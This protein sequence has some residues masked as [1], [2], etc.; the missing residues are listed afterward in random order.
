MSDSP[1]PHDPTDSQTIPGDAPGSFEQAKEAVEQG[2]AEGMGFVVNRHDPFLVV[3]FGNVVLNEPLPKSIKTL[4]ESLGATFTEATDNDNL[5]CIYKGQLPEELHGG[6]PVLVTL[7]G[8][9]G[10]IPVR[11]FDSGWTPMTGKH[12]EDTPGDVEQIDSDALEK[13]LKS[14]DKI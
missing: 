5:R 3:E 11:L 12:I 14:A 9:G 7:G 8:D 2:D 4:L 10:V 6:D 1:F 13:F